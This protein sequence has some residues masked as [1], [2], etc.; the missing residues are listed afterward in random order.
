MKIIE[1]FILLFV[2]IVGGG[3]LIGSFFDWLGEKRANAEIKRHDREVAQK[4]RKKMY[5]S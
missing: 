3:T 5:F 4:M 2:A 1:L